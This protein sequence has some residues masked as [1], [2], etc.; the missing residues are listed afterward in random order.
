MLS[1][2]EAIGK[3]P[4]YYF[5]AI[6]SGAGAIA[7]HEGAKR[8]LGDSRFDSILP[9]LMLSQNA[10]FAPMYDSWRAGRREF[11]ELDP[12]AARASTEKIVASVLSNQRPAYSIA[13]G[14]Y[15]VLRESRGD[16][17]AVS[18]EETLQAMALFERC[19]DI[20]ID[21]AAGVALAALTRAAHS[22]QI[23]SRAEILL[24][25]TG[26]GARKRAAQKTLVPVFADLEIAFHE[27]RS[28]AALESALGLFQGQEALPA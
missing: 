18:N 6:G 1:A 11:I 25:I 13:A 5:Q 9:R 12:D 19:E 14:I 4:D 27:L 28:D 3:L 15:D 10:P 21:P 7:A 23:Q 20:D 26:G 16:M 17:M 24:H 22:G 2:V 8:L